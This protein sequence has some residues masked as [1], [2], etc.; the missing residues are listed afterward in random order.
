MHVNYHPQHLEGMCLPL[1]GCPGRRL[2]LQVP[3]P[4]ARPPAVSAC[5]S[6]ALAAVLLPLDAS[7]ARHN[8]QYCCGCRMPNAQGQLCCTGW[9]LPKAVTCCRRSAMGTQRFAPAQQLEAAP[10]AAL[11]PG[12]AWRPHCRGRMSFC[13]ES[14]QTHASNRHVS[15]VNASLA[16]PAQQLNSAAEDTPQTQTASQRPLACAYG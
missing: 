6:S 2:L 1:P 9:R 12:A 10:R 3:A 4:P 16:L 13:A 14:M 8:W 11:G 15:T 7:K 5:T